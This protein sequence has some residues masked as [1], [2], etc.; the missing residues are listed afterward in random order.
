MGMVLLGLGGAA[1]L[2]LLAFA[3]G[4]RRGVRRGAAQA[5]HLPI[6]SVFGV[7]TGE[8]E[9]LR[10]AIFAKVFNL[11]P[12]TLTITRIADGRF[13]EVN[14]N[15]EALTGFTHEEAIG[16]TSNELGVWAV[17]EQREQIIERIRRDGEVHN[18]D[19]IF[20]HKQ[21]HLYYNKVSA[22][23]F[24]VR[25][26][27]YMMLSVQDVSA[28]RE[29]QQHIL[30]LNQ[31]LEDRVRQRTISLERSNAE[32]AEALQILE[33]AK[34][35]LVRSGKMA[36]LGSLVAG[37]AH[38]LNTPIGNGL[39]V[40]TTFEH[41]L[42]ELGQSIDSGLRRSTLDKFVVDARTGVDLLVRNLTRAGDLVR[43]FKQVAVDQSS[44]QRR[45]FL[46][47]E[48][49]SEI[50]MALNQKIQ[51]SGCQVVVNVESGLEM[52]SYPGPLGQVLSSLITNAL[53]HGFPEQARGTVEIRAH[54]V[55]AGDIEIVVKD[56]GA[57]ISAEN[58]KRVFDPFSLRDSVRAVRA[59][60]C[61]LLTTS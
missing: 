11:V 12:E 16:H 23:V 22:S 45:I 43:S 50:V 53:S 56:D 46:L 5:E 33:R 32:L 55:N 60:G 38:E 10:N 29:A 8:S 27:K 47:E 18:V 7:Q 1:V 2:A 57:G 58:L 51:Q 54:S 42:E 41:R 26:E 35:D 34:D 36:A 37:V 30:E 4:L 39:T 44:S 40:A 61:I 19:V 13:V 17:P 31:Q 3:A 24:E 9:V 20:L 6:E 28:Q 25:G 48:V 14:R 59:W 15:W 49:V 21:G 52:D